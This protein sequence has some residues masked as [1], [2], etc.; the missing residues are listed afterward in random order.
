MGKFNALLDALGI[1]GKEAKAVGDDAAKA[2]EKVTS[3]ET[4][5]GLKGEAKKQ[6]RDALNEIYGVR[7]QRASEDF[8]IDIEKLKKAEQRA[9]E[10]RKNLKFKLVEGPTP[11]TIEP[12]EKIPLDKDEYISDGNIYWEGDFV[13]SVASRLGGPNYQDFQ[14]VRVFDKKTGKQVASVPFAIHDGKI[15]I[16][17][18][19]FKSTEFEDPLNQAWTYV[20]PEARGKGIAQATY[21]ALE[22]KYGIPMTPSKKQTVEGKALWKK[23]S[24]SRPFGNVRKSDAAFDPRFKDSPLL[25]AGGLAG[26]NILPTTEQQLNPF[27]RLSD[28]AGAWETA[29][30]KVS[31]PLAKSLNLSGNPQDEAAF[32]QILKTGLDPLNFLPGAAGLAAGAAQMFTPSDEERAKKE[33]ED[34][35]RRRVLNQMAGQ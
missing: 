24:E 21:S 11:E 29:K 1:V 26:A 7:S 32:N 13:E 33:A 5:V 31:K 25:L 8:G 4:A 9:K 35:M 6:Y 16:A 3:A 20:V 19:Y 15:I 17:D 30:E 23:G 27:A 2:L 34:E 10:T 22:N 28:V 18:K 14:R 12:Y